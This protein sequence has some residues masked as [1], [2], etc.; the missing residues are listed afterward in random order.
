MMTHFNIS[1]KKLTGVAYSPA[2]AVS[3]MSYQ[4]P[5]ISYAW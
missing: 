3:H 1:K 2:V 4:A 5:A